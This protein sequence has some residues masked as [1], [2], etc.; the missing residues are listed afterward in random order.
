MKANLE[1]FLPT[2]EAFAQERVAIKGED[3]LQMR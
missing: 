1:F 2:G 3:L